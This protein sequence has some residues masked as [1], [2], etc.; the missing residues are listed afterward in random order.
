MTRTSSGPS[1]TAELF[2]HNYIIIFADFIKPQIAQFDPP[3]PKP[4]S[5]EPNMEW[6]GCTVCEISLFAFELYCDL[7]TGVRGH[8]KSSKAALFDRA[9]TTLLVV[10]YSKCGSIY[11]GN[12]SEI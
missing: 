4:Y 9:H 11:Y 5:L 6:I 2:V 1:A 7:E 12:V 10:F 3:T 8:S